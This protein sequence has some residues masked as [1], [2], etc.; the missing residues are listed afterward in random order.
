VRGVD[1]SQERHLLESVT[2]RG[3]RGLIAQSGGGNT[4]AKRIS[5][6]RTNKV[7]VGNFFWKVIQ[8]A[9]APREGCTTHR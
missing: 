5:T 8:P 2:H 3:A 6:G 4:I 1:T 9:G 7:E